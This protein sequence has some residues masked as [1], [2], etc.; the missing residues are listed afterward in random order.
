VEHGSGT[1]QVCRTRIVHIHERSRLGEKIEGERHIRRKCAG[2]SP[3]ILREL[4]SSGSAFM[5]GDEVI[6][7]FFFGVV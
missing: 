3:K 6:D 4:A 5:G 7:D 1:P 2:K